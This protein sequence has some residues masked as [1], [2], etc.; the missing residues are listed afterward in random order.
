MEEL[1]AGPDVEDGAPQGPD[2][3]CWAGRLADDNLRGEVLGRCAELRK[4]R[5]AFKVKRLIKIDD[6]KLAD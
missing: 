2:V 4:W 3:R 5:G 6:A 1:I